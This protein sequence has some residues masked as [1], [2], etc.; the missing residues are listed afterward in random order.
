MIRGVIMSNIENLKMKLF[1]EQI[2]VGIE[3]DSAINKSYQKAV[4]SLNVD[5]KIIDDCHEVFG[6]D[7]SYYVCQFLKNFFASLEDKNS[8]LVADAKRDINVIL[9]A[10]VDQIDEVDIGQIETMFHHLFADLLVRISDRKVYGNID[11]LISVNIQ[12]YVATKGLDD[13]QEYSDRLEQLSTRIRIMIQ[14]F[15]SEILN[16]SKNTIEEILAKFI[17]K[18]L[19]VIKSLELNSEMQL[20][21]EFDKSSSPKY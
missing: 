20:A 16:S 3:I 13:K 15:L 10:I 18:C 11:S 12:H 6:Y 9:N 7:V 8:L 19:N 5:G 17:S 2:L 4:S 21:E 14:E 1:K